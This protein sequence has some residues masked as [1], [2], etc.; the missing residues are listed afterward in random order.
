MKR[1]SIKKI[2][3]VD[4]EPAIRGFI[5]AAL[6]PHG[7]SID[8]AP[9]GQE[10]LAKIC[11]WDYDLVVTDVMMPLL[12]GMSLYKIASVKMP[13]LRSRF[14]FMTAAVTELNERFFKE[15]GYNHLRKPFLNNE[16]LEKISEIEDS[17]SAEDRRETKRVS[18][19]S[20]RCLI[21]SNVTMDGTVEDISVDGMLVRYYGEP[22]AAG[23]T[24]GVFF[25]NA[26]LQRMAEVAWSTSLNGEALSGL[27]VQE[28]IPVQS[29]LA[30]LGAPTPKMA[31][32]ARN[33]S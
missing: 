7:Y 5:R 6:T 18:S 17:G 19:L 31:E 22:L 3:V 10:A 29:V 26:D 28:C 15:N 27:S 2:L 30:A 23:H 20:T 21:V 32:A 9:D 33:G 24:V 13:S 16:L 25:K 14:I 11:S 1:G 12:D 8:E 4:D